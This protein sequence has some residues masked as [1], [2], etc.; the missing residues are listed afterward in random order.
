MEDA[1]CRSKWSFGVNQIEV[2]L[3]T[4]TCWGYYQILIIGLSPFL[5]AFGVILVYWGWCQCVALVSVWGFC[6][7]VCDLRQCSSLVLLFFIHSF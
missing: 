4:L 7:P 6:V 1:L 5:M 2:N 3:A